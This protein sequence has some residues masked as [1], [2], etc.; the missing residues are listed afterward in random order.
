MGDVDTVMIHK[1]LQSLFTIIIIPIQVAVRI[2]CGWGTPSVELRVES[3]ELRLVLF[4]E[5]DLAVGEGIAKPW[6]GLHEIVVEIPCLQTVLFIIGVPEVL[7][8][9]ATPLVGG[10]KTRAL[11]KSVTYHVFPIVCQSVVVAVVNPGGRFEMSLHVVQCFLEIAWGSGI[12]F[13]GV[14]TAVE[15]DPVELLQQF[16]VL[17]IQLEVIIANT[18][19][20]H[21]KL[22]GI[23]W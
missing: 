7:D 8:A 11:A 20:L 1:S 2:Q 19:T 13:G 16:L 17:L 5:G 21:H 9:V 15:S 4:Q 6:V 10:E 18:L 23:P 22:A 3:G 14:Q 12:L